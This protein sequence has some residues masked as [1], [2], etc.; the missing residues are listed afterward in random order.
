MFWKI[1]ATFSISK[2]AKKNPGDKRPAERQA[3]S[4]LPWIMCKWDYY[5]YI[6]NSHII[7]AL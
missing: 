5:I 4:F 3:I 2:L 6:H 7:S 1:L